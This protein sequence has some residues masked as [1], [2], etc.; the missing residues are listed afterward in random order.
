MSLLR[1][2][3]GCLLLV[4][5]TFFHL[6]A[7]EGENLAGAV[8]SG[9]VA[10]LQGMVSIR[11][12][13]HRRWTTATKK[14]AILPGD[15]VRT[16][17]RGANAVMLEL[18]GG[19]KVTLGPGSRAEVVDG[20]S[21]RLLAGDAE[22]VPPEKGKLTVF[23]AGGYEDPVSAT[24]LFRADKGEI[25][26]LAWDPDW[27]KGFKGVV[28]RES[29]GSL[30]A[31]VDG[32][33]VPLTL[34]YHK[35]TVDIRDQIARTVIEE[36]FVNRTDGVLEG[37]FYFP[38]PAGAS[39]SGFGM[40]I[41]GELVEA[42]VVEKQRAREI[43][44]T[45]LR[46]KRDPGLLEWTG[47]NMFKARVYPINPNSEKRVKISYTEVLPLRG[48]VFRYTYGLRSEL[49]RQYPLR[50]LDI[51]VKIHSTMKIMG[52]SCP[53]HEVRAGNTEHSA[54]I[55]FG[56]EE[57]T[58][59]AD[60]EV[61]VQVQRTGAGAVFVPHRRGDDGYFLLL[62][63]PPAANLKT[64]REELPDSAPL[65]LIFLAD[66]SGSMDEVARQAQAR[67]FSAALSLLSEEDNF[68]LAAVDAHV[69]WLGDD[70]LP[71]SFE[72]LD[73]ALDFLG[74]RTSL[75]WTDLDGA[76]D[77]ALKKAG[78]N[79]HII[80]LGDGMVTTKAADPVAFA[81]RLEA[82]ASGLEVSFH[83]V[84]PGNAYEPAVLSA[85]AAAGKGTYRRVE[86]EER[87]PEAA[88]ALLGEIIRPSLRDVKVEFTGFSTARVYPDVIPAVAI[89]AQQVVLGRYLP[90]GARGEGRVVVTGLLNGEPL[91][92]SAPVSFAADEKGNS[93]IP[94]LWAR[95]HLDELL[96][97]GRSKGIQEEIVHLSEEYQ[98]ITPY[99]S[100]LVLES[101]ADRARFGVKRRFRIRDGERF[102]ADGRDAAEFELLQQ[103][104]KLAGTW[105]L[106]L[107]DAVLA[108]IAGLGRHL[109]QSAYGAYP[110]GD[111]NGKGRLLGSAGGKDYS[112]RMAEQSISFSSSSSF[113]RYEL[114]A[115]SA[116]PAEFKFMDEETESGR[117]DFG[118]EADREKGDWANAPIV[119]EPPAIMNG[120][121]DMPLEL[122]GNIATKKERKKA[123]S[124]EVMRGARISS[125]KHRISL[126]TT[127]SAGESY[128]SMDGRAA[129]GPVSL[130]VDKSGSMDA[131]LDGT[132]YSDP[133]SSWFYR[134]F[135]TLPAPPVEVEAPERETKWPDDALKLSAE[136]HKWKDL[137][138]LDTPLKVETETRY[139][140]QPRGTV[141]SV[142][143]TLAYLW[144]EGW[145]TR[146]SGP[147][148][149]TTLA[150]CEGGE[151]GAIH[152]PFG[153]GRVRSATAGECAPMPVYLWT[154]AFSSL[155]DSYWNYRPVIEQLGQDRIKVS[156]LAAEK[157]PDAYGAY[158]VIDMKRKVVLEAESWYAGKLSSKSIYSDFVEAGGVWWPGKIEVQDA[159]GATTQIVTMTVAALD[160][161]GLRGAAG[162]ELSVRR[163][164][165]I[166]DYPLMSAGAARRALASGKGTF[167]A[168]LVMLLSYSFSQRWELAQLHLERLKTLAAK[169]PG[170]YWLE[171]AVL[172]M[173]REHRPLAARVLE[174]A[175]KTATSPTLDEMFLAEF[176]VDQTNQMFEANEQLELL[177]LLEPLF[178]RQPA[179][180]LGRKKWLEK[181]TYAFQMTGRQDEVFRL[182]KA[183]AEE[184]SWDYNALYQYAWELSNRGE[185]TEA[186]RVLEEALQ[187]GGPWSTWEDEYLR[188]QRLELFRQE[189]RFKEKV[190]YLEAWL[191]REPEGTT[192]YQHYLSALVRTGNLEQID[193]TLTAWFAEAKPGKLSTAAASRIQAAV[194][195]ALGQGWGMY[196]N[197]LDKRWLPQL[198]QVVKALAGNYQHTYLAQTVAQHG[199][200]ARTDQARALRK[201]LLVELG[202]SVSTIEPRVVNNYITL[203]TLGG[204]NPGDKK[205]WLKIAA[206]LETR[207]AKGE[208]VNERDL[209]AGSIVTL[210]RSHAKPARLLGFLRKQLELGHKDRRSAHVAQLFAEL[211][212]Q[213]WT[214]KLE[215]EV[216][217][218]LPRLGE[219]LH[220]RE[221][222][223]SRVDGLMQFVNG[224]LQ[225]RFQA[226]W[227]AVED[228]EDLSRTELRKQQEEA[229]RRAR[230]G[231]AARLATGGDGLTPDLAA[232]AR[233]ERLY[234]LTVLEEKL[235]EVEAECW[236]FVKN[237]PG[238]AVDEPTEVPAPYGAAS[239]P[240]LGP[241]LLVR[242]LGIL[243]YLATL[244]GTGEPLAEKL[245]SY[246]ADRR[247][248]EPEV[249]QWHDYTYRLL[250]ALDRP[251]QLEKLLRTWL[252]RTDAAAA[253]R[254]T[255]G[256]LVAELGR[257]DEA[258]KLFESMEKDGELGPEEY[259][260]LA[261][262]YT[263][264]GKRAEQ[265]KALVARYQTIPEWELSNQLS[266]MQ[267]GAVAEPGGVPVEVDSEVRHIFV[268][269]FK[270]ASQPQSYV[271]QLSDFYR[272]YRD[273]R[274]F[275][276]LAE[277]LMGH[278]PGK[279]YPV[280]QQLAYLLE[281]VRDEAAADSILAEIAR[282]RA[283]VKA[284]TD[285][286][287][288]DLL[289]LMVERRASEVLNQ[290]GPH[291]KAALAAMQR[292][293]K[294]D[295]TN[296]EP[297]LM[298]GV[299]AALGR[300]T[301]NPLA[302]EQLRQLK[303]LHGEEQSGS[304]DRLKIAADWAN[305]LWA[306]SDFNPAIDVLEG[307]Y[308]EA[309]ELTS[310]RGLGK[311]TDPALPQHAVAVFNSLI[312][313][314]DSR[315]HFSR[316][317]RLLQEEI[318]YAP[319]DRE[320]ATRTQR[321]HQLY[322]S[323]LSRGGSVSLGSGAALYEAAQ[324]LMLAH[325]KNVR[326]D[327]AYYTV[328]D[329]CSLYSTAFYKSIYKSRGD[330]RDF[331][332]KVVPDT[333]SRQIHNYQGVVSQVGGTL[334]SVLG[335]REA[336]A[337]LVERI[338][339]EP[340]WLRWDGQDGWNY[341]SYSLAQWRTE[342]KDLGPLD[343]RLLKVVLSVLR[344]DLTSGNMI[345]RNM[346]AINY[347]NF[348]QEKKGDFTRVAEE[349]YRKDKDSAATVQHVAAY[350]FDGLG[351]KKRAAAMMEE[352]YRKKLLQLDGKTTL[353]YYLFQIGGHGRAVP[354]LKDMVASYPTSSRYRADLMIAYCKSGGKGKARKLLKASDKYLRETGIWATGDLASLADACVIC[355]LFESA[356]GYY[357][358]LI[359]LHQR[360]THRRGIG[361]GILSGY[362]TRQAE[363]YAGLGKTLEAV[364]AASGAVVSWG[365]DVYN[366]QQALDSLGSVLR[367]SGDLAAFT[368]SL[369]K[370]VAETGLENP[371]VRK[372]LGR[373]LV[374]KGKVK[375]GLIQL[376]ASLAVSPNDADTHRLIYDA[377][378]KSGDEEGA[379]EQLIDMVRLVRRDLELY[380]ELG[381]RFSR[382]HNAEQAERAYTSLVEMLT[383]DSE[384]HAR[385]A[386]VREGQNRWP[387]AIE[388]WEQVIRIRT[389]EPAGYLGLAAALTHEKRWEQA[390]KTV[391][392]LLGRKWPPRF[393]DVH[394]QAKD[395]RGKINRQR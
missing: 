240:A 141:N 368:V 154:W 322:V 301:D 18:S 94:R 5:C 161:K 28:T 68:R 310:R 308:R 330:L 62:I 192:A 353:V 171:N 196:T 270:K 331:A 323:T 249:L 374:N 332:W 293:F 215:D 130:V 115:A 264:Q 118:V 120:L 108:D 356:V 64:E 238:L 164:S 145:V 387:E 137:T 302:V 283:Q 139:T 366:R 188:G 32:R 185:F 275:G 276:C 30:L 190:A 150:W 12:A 247:K 195:H 352:A 180:L 255:L 184:F 278:T 153:L 347:G 223:Y 186:H 201:E 345:N 333:L 378:V 334:H 375:E 179:H 344:R 162:A 167:E 315:S 117:W 65:D 212:V 107:R 37:V 111:M 236:E 23:G 277:G 43:Y 109:F 245:L 359:P 373:V 200:F 131:I 376:R 121:A 86:N 369:D 197:R 219:G 288:L 379:T 29:M 157:T 72:N 220:E 59:T 74:N 304:S 340:E 19:G 217:A 271:W 114:P 136:L 75:G 61:E 83:A 124:K 213:P 189:G 123:V 78:P 39:V 351:L 338:L 357:D 266:Y 265:T 203:S 259:R 156:F 258:V 10:D 262:W 174:W 274:L 358:E 13:G 208:D 135:P 372:A 113:Y 289:E 70:P 98:I 237:S 81:R 243:E 232:W 105:R 104:M 303:V 15:Q 73:R 87:A 143:T 110:Y 211:L 41:G 389:N 95:L 297:A 319:N 335:A 377:L 172:L 230:S 181:K 300:I 25:V 163:T 318:T 267:R 128:W 231:V 84:A 127:P 132:R 77:E 60:L 199:E 268:A 392:T 52:V 391:N 26:I 177:D 125:G 152:L 85:I 363:A 329:L 320:R 361:D 57:Y 381:D 183:L 96:E 14:L 67:F 225:A 227:K 222:A 45:I 346:Y 305:T 393:G 383:D 253:W 210:F 176:V 36:S 93:F 88:Y 251:A 27:L 76:F 122:A 286:R 326:H 380:V 40:W 307:A 42:D 233:V 239:R 218:L 206:I 129:A 360:I 313:Y 316:A 155:E 273:F 47:G 103:Q 79:T 191:A 151:R 50:E 284:P 287:A 100:L 260:A 22:V 228:K 116:A 336:L 69:H 119:E 242:Y 248:E 16:G 282:V 17:V 250:V 198:V 53:T 2:Y 390:M 370:Q 158:L 349:V 294:G 314:L 325:L 343:K 312:G 235:G 102:F 97:Q 327:A 1:N 384:A 99:T 82:L 169:R 292:A 202:R 234:L 106:G 337:F 193:K 34:G 7:A 170:A 214:Q 44:E 101:D 20:G 140:A 33:N 207:W 311:G 298:S 279:V 35:V 54:S 388:R 324:A 166:A 168:H 51:E 291:S 269:L 91:E 348:W 38:L 309:L 134:L 224:M 147:G 299:L 175:K 244:P 194:Y 71:P 11:S 3:V 280:F 21:V 321:L 66:T 371:I 112:V 204:E 261:G 317:E 89:G 80:Y 256:Y 133:Y 364:E 395:L 126:A 272:N 178:A 173:S 385:L 4:C 146:T 362:Y 382:Q 350:M 290:P 92:L 246:Y 165:L 221:Q 46:E 160:R 295:W 6:P 257:L 58:P 209:L 354:V 8:R 138:E 263:V 339:A 281:E 252:E 9:R 355:E 56:A 306:Y 159:E 365:E 31:N 386:A 241:L 216:F 254:I 49:T 296:G 342:V 205:T 229:I 55:E 328:S 226:V 367:K 182:R 63:T 341:H 394:G 90:E 24:K 187:K 285:L 148:Q 48:D 149:A 144:K 142:N